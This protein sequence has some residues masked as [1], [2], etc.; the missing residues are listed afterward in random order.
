M[1]QIIDRAQPA[2]QFLPHSLNLTIWRGVAFVLPL[3]M[4]FKL[5][6]TEVQS[7]NVETLARYYQEFQQGKVRILIAF[8]HPC[9]SDPFTMGYLM[10]K[11]LPKVA[12]EHRI[13]LKRP[14]HSHFLY[15]RGVAL[16]AGNIVNWLFPTIGGS[17]IFR[18]KADRE[19]LKAA[20]ALLTDSFIPLSIAP[21]GATNDHSELV[22]PLE[23]GVAQLGFWAQDD[24]IKAERPESMFIIPVSL[25]YQYI[26]P[27]WGEIE[28]IIAQ[29]ESDLK[30]PISHEAPG[31]INDPKA[32]R[33]YGRL[34]NVGIGFLSQLEAF[35]TRNYGISFEEE[36]A[37]S[38]DHSSIN[39]VLIERLHRGLDKIL[40]VSEDFFNVKAK[41][42][43]SDR[44]RRLE[45]A[46]WSRIFIDKLEQLSPV[47]RGLA[48][49]QA[50]EASLRLDHMRLAERLICLTDDYIVSKPTGDR[51]AEVSLILWRISVWL[52]GESPHDPPKLG[53]KRVKIH[54]C[55]P[56]AIQ[57]YWA[58]Y[59]LDRRSAR[60]TVNSITEKIQASFEAV[61][62]SEP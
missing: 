14:V 18:G 33:L 11:E 39:Q 22:S 24:L 34:L 46:A 36:E 62:Q 37:P 13:A 6:I 26:K 21:E 58:Q 27:P 30:L 4:R 40:K 47:E 31:F 7:Q 41:G 23:P 49:W 32:D 8:R 56:I 20:R 50:A 19:G 9:T 25:R 3:W 10:W 61:I 45:Q 28:K 59:K 57:D 35:Y 1:P 60:K 2:L 54:V 16:W 17:S 29:L 12:K 44:C 55:E 43:F 48:D 38:T 5:A 51:F 52:K 53:P 42:E 15:D